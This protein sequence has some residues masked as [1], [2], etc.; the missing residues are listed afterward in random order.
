[1]GIRRGCPVLRAA[2]QVNWVDGEIHVQGVQTDGPAELAGI[3]TRD[4]IVGIGDKPAKEFDPFQL[5]QLLTSV[6]GRRVPLTIRRADR[7]IDVEL[8][9]KED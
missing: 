7:E 5:R 3:R 1:M 4:V 6:G 9:L 2:A 8:T